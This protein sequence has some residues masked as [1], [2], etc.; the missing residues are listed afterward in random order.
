MKHFNF[1]NKLLF[2]FLLSSIFIHL[3]AATIFVNHAAAGADDGSSWTDAYNDLQDALAAAT[4]GDEIWVAQ[5]TYFPTSGTDESISFVMQDGVGIY[6]GFTG[7]ITETQLSDR[8]WRVN[9]TTLSGEI[10]AAGIAD[11]SYHVLRAGA[12][13]NNSILDGFTITAGN[14]DGQM[15]EVVQIV[16]KVVEC[17]FQV[18]AWQE[19]IT[20]YSSIIMLTLEEVQ[21]K[22]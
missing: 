14:A 20:V 22:T 16:I 15:V 2:T 21:S 7:I 8:D 6:G 19:L 1:S 18:D 12:M 3:Q 11:N 9:V 17:L 10:G 13:G 5:G 4:N